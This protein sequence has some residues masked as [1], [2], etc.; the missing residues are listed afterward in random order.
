[1]EA[2]VGLET[3][4]LVQNTE[5]GGK[6]SVLGVESIHYCRKNVCMNACLIMHAGRERAD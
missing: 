5:S 4:C 3:L 6:V 2:E 1:M